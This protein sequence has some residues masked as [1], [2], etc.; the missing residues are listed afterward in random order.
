MHSDVS[1]NA[2]EVLPV[3]DPQFMERCYF[4]AELQ[5]EYLMQVSGKGAKGSS[6]TGE[7]IQYSQV[8]ITYDAI[9]VWGYCHKRVGDNVLLVDR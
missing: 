8:N 2:A 9:P 3:Y 7:P 5:G 1:I 4:P 6:N